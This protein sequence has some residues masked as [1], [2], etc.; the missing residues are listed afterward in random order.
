MSAAT[1]GHKCPKRDPLSRPLRVHK[2]TGTSLS[3]RSSVLMDGDTATNDKGSSIQAAACQT[4][5]DLFGCHRHVVSVRAPHLTQTRVKRCGSTSK[6]QIRR[7]LLSTRNGARLR[8]RDTYGAGPLPTA[9]QKPRGTGCLGRRAVPTATTTNDMA[10]WT[11]GQVHDTVAPAHDTK[12]VASAHDATRVACEGT[13][14]GGM[15]N[16]THEQHRFGRRNPAFTAT[17]T[18]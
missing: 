18:R 4:L 6:A 16:T 11:I 17:Q 15:F 13:T 1:T 9:A 12:R 10:T 14:Q 7:Q 8:A 3:W 2:D 5:S